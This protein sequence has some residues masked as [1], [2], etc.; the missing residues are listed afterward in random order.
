MHVVKG[1]RLLLGDPRHFHAA[2][3]EPGLFDHR[4]NLARVPASY[5]IRLDDCK[6]LFDCHV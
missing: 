5:R 6:C 4:E 1:F 2:N 3:A